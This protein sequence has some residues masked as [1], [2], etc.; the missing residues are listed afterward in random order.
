MQVEYRTK[1]EGWVG[2]RMQNKERRGA[3]KWNT[4]K[5]RRGT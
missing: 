1:K 4:D 2:G 3:Y 5:E